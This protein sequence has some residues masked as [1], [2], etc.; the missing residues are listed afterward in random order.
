[1]KN[2]TPAKPNP[3]SKTS[4]NGIPGS[5]RTPT[6]HS[7]AG[8]STV[9]ESVAEP[10]PEETNVGALRKERDLFATILD[11][12]KDLLV[13]VLDP[14]GRI[15]HFNRGCQELT[16]YSLAEVRGR[17]PVDFLLL[18]EEAAGVEAVF[19]QLLHAEPN[20]YENYCVTK[21][22]RRLLIRWSNSVSVSGGVLEYVIGTGID[23]TETKRAEE[24]VHTYQQQLRQLTAS[25]ISSQEDEDRELARELHD[26]FSQELAAASME[27]SMLL[28]SKD[29]SGPF[30]VRLRDLGK[31]LARMAD[32]IHGT[33][34][35]L[36]PAI[37]EDLGLEAAL[38]EECRSFENQF[39]IATDF[40]S[41][42]VPP[43]MPT[44]VALCLYR[45]AQES[46][47]NIAKHSQAAAVY[48]R[49]TGGRVRNG[50]N[51]ITLRVDDQ[52]DGFDLDRALKKGGLGFISMEERVRLV[53]GNLE[54]QSQPNQGTT[55]TAFVPLNLGAP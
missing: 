16:G 21:D 26:V 5:S 37:L 33:A 1:M 10:S 38:R 55:V 19:E 2:G 22:G 18:P 32:E 24:R 13:V 20:Q 34:R 14:Q 53:G 17:N 48:V 9:K 12:A 44:E 39:H 28:E 15:I 11:T 41:R 6:E 45:V 35:R 31:K 23:I 47:R 51:A 36:H 8:I 40:F 29:A 30:T 42:D 54:I 7:G 4:S 25:L 3:K 27:V 50:A 52:G 49:L 46:L 43:S